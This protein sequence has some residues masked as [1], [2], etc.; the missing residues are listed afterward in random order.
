MRAG[1][2]ALIAV[3]CTGCS[4]RGG[5]MDDALRDQVIEAVQQR[6]RSFE[7][8]ERE[9][10][11]ERLLGHFSTRRDFYMYSDGQRIT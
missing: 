1:L 9:L 4:S 10:D 11:A 8:A 2:V 5:Q 3:A 6:V 7:A